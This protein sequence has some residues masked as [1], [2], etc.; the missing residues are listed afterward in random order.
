[1]F[2]F[3]VAVADYVMKWRRFYDSVNYGPSFKRDE[4]DR[5][6]FFFIKTE[7]SAQY[8][9]CLC[10]CLNLIQPEWN[11]KTLLVLNTD[12]LKD[13]YSLTEHGTKYL[14]FHL[15][16]EG[17]QNSFWLSSLLIWASLCNEINRTFILWRYWDFPQLL[18]TVQFA[19]VNS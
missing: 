3:G 7:V 4:F 6:T 18:Y 9:Q 1:M 19:K 8:L 16:V 17:A 12:E 10:S 11:T 5:A 14:K 2:T 15:A 13:F